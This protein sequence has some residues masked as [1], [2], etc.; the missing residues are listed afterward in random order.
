[1]PKHV[2]DRT[3]ALPSA[4]LSRFAMIERAK[5]PHRSVKALVARRLDRKNARMSAFSR[6][7]RGITT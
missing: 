4:I 5:H 2:I 7:S 6:I 1:M 3:R